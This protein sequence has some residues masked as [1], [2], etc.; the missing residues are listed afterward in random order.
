MPSRFYKWFLLA[1][2]LGCS[3]EA[4]P[5]PK[6]APQAP[7]SASAVPVP[8][9]SAKP[10]SGKY[11]PGQRP[12]ILGSYDTN[13]LNKIDDQDRADNIRRIAELLNRVTIEPGAVLSFNERVGRRTKERGFKEAPTYY[14]GEIVP[15]IG[16]G[17]CQVSSTVH[18]AAIYAGLEIVERRPHSRP[19]RYIDRG[20]DATVNYEGEND[21]IDLKIRNIYDKPVVL[22]VWTERAEPDDERKAKTHHKT[23]LIVQ[24]T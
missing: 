21:D 7:P 14:L 1:V 15:G 23:T 4:P 11:Q 10:D 17:T 5:G 3:K 22:D 19:A 9:A 16:G 13:F 20:L 2:V 24:V 18:A 6:E 8:S 12:P